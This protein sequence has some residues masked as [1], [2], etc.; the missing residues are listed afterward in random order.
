MIVDWE[1]RYRTGEAPWERGTLHPA[2]R[3]WR[4]QGAFDGLGRVLVPGAGRAPE[5]LAFARLGVSP[6]VVDLAPSAIGHQERAFAGAGLAGDFILSD[7]LAYVPA[8]PFDAV[9]DQTAMCALEPALWPEYARQLAR[10]V[11]P[12]GRLFA[13]LL[14]R[15]EVDGKGPPYH[16]DVAA[17]RGLLGAPD[18]TWESAAPVIRVPHPA[19]FVELGFVLRRN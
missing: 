19:G 16:Q 12:G 6:T 18:W 11:R 10:W 4:E 8:E 1:E 3:H 15:P 17:M 9:Y 14:Q 7:L 2:F 13:L 5:P